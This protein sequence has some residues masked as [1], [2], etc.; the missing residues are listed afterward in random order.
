MKPSAL[1]FLGCHPASF[2]DRQKIL[3]YPCLQ[4][5]LSVPFPALASGLQPNQL[6]FCSIHSLQQLDIQS[7]IV[8]M[9]NPRSQSL[10]GNPRILYPEIKRSILGEP[11]DLCMPWAYKKAPAH[12]FD[13][14]FQYT[15]HIPCRRSRRRSKS[16]NEAVIVCLGL[17]V[18]GQQPLPQIYVPSID[19]VL[20]HHLTKGRYSVIH[21]GPSLLR[22][23][24]IHP[25]FLFFAGLHGHEIRY[26]S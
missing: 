25:H 5:V 15:D 18:Q 13:S 14:V 2:Q 7:K 3:G 20:S 22:V 8:S 21:T 16:D 9:A 26:Y 1:L 10:V 6:Q 4:V 24:C 19:S 23:I 12:Y 11:V 17:I